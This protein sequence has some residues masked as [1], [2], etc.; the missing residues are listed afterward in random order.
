M[1]PVRMVT[2]DADPLRSPGGRMRNIGL[3]IAVA[4]SSATPVFA[5]GALYCEMSGIVESAVHR[6]NR[7]VLFGPAAPTYDLRVAVSE[8]AESDRVGL[9]STECGDFVGSAIDIRLDASDGLVIPQ[10]GDRIAFSYSRIDV[11]GVN[12]HGVSACSELLRL[13]AAENHQRG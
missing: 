9:S 5:S 8:S 6:A 13:V 3:L 4:M 1:T 2:G 10:V 7:K 12:G 11:Y